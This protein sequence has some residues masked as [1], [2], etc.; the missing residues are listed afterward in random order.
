MSNF[1]VKILKYC[2]NK[3]LEKFGHG[4]M[5]Y[6]LDALPHCTSNFQKIIMTNVPKIS[7]KKPQKS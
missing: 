4:L 5:C 6:L 2:K 3:K 1:G 7:S